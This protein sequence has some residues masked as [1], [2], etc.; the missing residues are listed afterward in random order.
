[1]I[2]I[3]NRIFQIGI[4]VPC[5]NEANRIPLIEFERHINEN[6]NYFFCF[7]NDGSTDITLKTV[8]TLSWKYPDRIAIVDNKINL[9]KAEAVRSG[10]NYLLSEEK[11]DIL[12]FL[13]A[14][15]STPLD[16]IEKLVTLF[17]NDK[18]LIVF[19][20]RIKHVGGYVERE[21]IR[22]I[23][24]RIFATVVSSWLL[25]IAVY[26]TQCG[27]KFFRPIIVKPLFDET[28]QSKWFFDIELFCRIKK[29]FPNTDI[30][31]IAQEFFITTW[32]NEKGSKI[33]LSDY[34]NAPLELIKLKYHYKV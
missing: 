7:V 30:N 24:G 9:G 17:N 10:I 31:E 2:E 3:K 25:K 13:D 15:L 32:K 14:D 16:E 21:F 33:K 34:F 23:L 12:G 20:S 5:Y 19:G 28:F 8:Q 11:F 6:Q 4:V 22:Y 18:K 26:D 27:F 29:N 1:M